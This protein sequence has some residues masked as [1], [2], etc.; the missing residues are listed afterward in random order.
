MKTAMIAPVGIMAMIVKA[1]AA[2]GRV[3]WILCRASTERARIHEK[4]RTKT[5]SISTHS[6]QGTVFMPKANATGAT[7]ISNSS[8]NTTQGTIGQ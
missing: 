5:R 8:M 1:R 7:S 4:G 3:P 2:I 6:G